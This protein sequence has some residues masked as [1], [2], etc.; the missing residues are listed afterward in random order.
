M[1]SPFHG[2]P[3]LSGVPTWLVYF[4]ANP[5]TRLF[6]S[7]PS[8]LL[9]DQ[10]M[11]ECLVIANPETGEVR[12]HLVS[13]V[14]TLDAAVADLF[15]PELNLGKVYTIHANSVLGRLTRWHGIKFSKPIPQSLQPRYAIDIVERVNAPAILSGNWR[16]SFRIADYVETL[17][18]KPAPGFDHETGLLIDLLNRYA[19]Y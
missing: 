7:C 6:P 17:G 11:P 4:R 16:Y 15:N 1:S 19:N 3:P 10:E 8:A 2:A 13:N 18:L 9:G 5:T 14:T 12:E